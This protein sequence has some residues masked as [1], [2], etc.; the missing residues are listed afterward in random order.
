MAT[1]FY[2]GIEV[3]HI[4]RRWE[5]RYGDGDPFQLFQSEFCQKQT[6]SYPVSPKIARGELQPF[7]A[8]HGRTSHVQI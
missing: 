7:F 8:S 4:G 6:A 1:P 3:G 2:A 5:R